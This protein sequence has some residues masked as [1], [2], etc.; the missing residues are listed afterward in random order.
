MSDTNHR[1][2][3][4]LCDKKMLNKDY[5]KHLNKE[6]I[7]DIFNDVKNRKELEELADKKNGRNFRPIELKVKDK[8]LYFVPCC[9]KYY[10]KMAHAEKHNTKKECYEKVL[11]EAKV[12]L[13][14]INNGIDNT[15]KPNTTINNNNTDISGNDNTVNNTTNII[16]N[17]NF[18][19]LSGN[20]IKTICKEV[21]G[22]I[23]SDR[24]DKVYYFKKLNK[25]KSI[26]QDHPDYDSSV[27]TVDSAYDSDD[28]CDTKLERIDLDKEFNKYNK[29]TAKQL[30]EVNIDLSRKNLGLKTKEISMKLK[31]EKKKQ[32][33]EE[34][35]FQKEQEQEERSIKIGNLRADSISIKNNIRYLENIHNEYIELMNNEKSGITE[36]I[37]N[38]EYSQT[39]KINK[40][41]KDLEEIK[42]ELSKLH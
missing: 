3:C 39:S 4:S 12:I 42:K 6:H 14:T 21:C 33:E 22:I 30:S 23:D 1:I 35:K 37:F 41:K 20:L 18:Y 34:E 25:L 19:D 9:K 27:S 29:K 5:S 16:N 24:H 26:F 31:E 2:D 11:E 13:E 38:K 36:E 32:K 17:Y 10:S 40:L 7:S 15:V 8:E 28:E